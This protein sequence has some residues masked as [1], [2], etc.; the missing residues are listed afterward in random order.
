MLH[1]FLCCVCSFVLLVTEAAS[2]NHGALIWNVSATT[3]DN[4]KSLLQNIVGSAAPGK[5][6]ALLG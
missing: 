1:L 5:L 4:K 3:N 6:H 2:P